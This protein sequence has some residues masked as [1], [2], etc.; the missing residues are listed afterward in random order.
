M[1]TMRNPRLLS[2]LLT[3]PALAG[4][5]LVGNSSASAAPAAHD[6]GRDYDARPGGRPFY[7]EQTLAQGPDAAF[8]N[9]RIPAL[10]VSPRG[11]VLVS[12]DGRPTAIDAPGP[13]SILQ[14][15]SR[16]GGRTVSVSYAHPLPG[17]LEGEVRLV[18]VTFE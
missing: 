2:A 12:Y 10:T 4:A 7:T 18:E 13:N 11:D 1:F 5:T 15:R 6:G 8:P 17:F 16:D 9:Y 3:I 14:R